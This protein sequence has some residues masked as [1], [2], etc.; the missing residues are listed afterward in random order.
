MWCKNNTLAVPLSPL[1]SQPL[2]VSPLPSQRECG[3]RELNPHP[4]G[5]RAG[6]VPLH[7]EHRQSVP[8]P[9]LEPGTSRS[10]REMMAFSP[11]G[12]QCRRGEL[13]PVAVFARHS[14]GPPASTVDRGQWSRGELNPDAVL[15]R[16]SSSPLASA[17][18]TEVGVEPTQ[19]RLSTCRL[20]R[21]AYP[22]VQLRSPGLEPGSQAYETRPSTRPPA[23]TET[24]CGATRTDPAGR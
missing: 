18:V 21:L 23:S 24:V 9:G 7:H 16:H 14:S 19:H 12:H 11:P 1:A 15:A 4:G 6:C 3:R 5:H 2:E 13:N 20:C 22:V 8:R 17:S 10:K